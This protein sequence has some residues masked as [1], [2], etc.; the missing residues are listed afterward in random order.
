MNRLPLGLIES[1]RS[2]TIKDIKG[3]G[4]L[5]RQLLEQGLVDGCRVQVVRN[6]EGGPLI[7]SIKDTRLAIGRGASLQILVEAAGEAK[8]LTLS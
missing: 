7:I 4:L 1:G 3:S 8:F 2:A 5:K 6:D